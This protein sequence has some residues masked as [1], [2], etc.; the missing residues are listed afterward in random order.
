[1]IRRT[2][3]AEDK[4]SLFGYRHID[5]LPDL[6]LILEHSGVRNLCATVTYSKII[7]GRFGS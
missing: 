5:D 4:S 1:M 3:P 7:A 2:V 6:S